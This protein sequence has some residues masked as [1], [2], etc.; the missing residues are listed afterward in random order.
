MARPQTTWTA[1]ALLARTTDDAGCLVWAGRVHSQSGAPLVDHQGKSRMARR[2]LLALLGRTVRPS[3]FVRCR[4]G[5]PGCIHPDH[6]V[7]LPRATHMREVAASPN[8]NEAVRRA[9]IAATRRARH[10][11][12]TPEQVQEIRASD[13]SGAAIARRL[14]VG[15][16]T[17]N[18]I[19]RG[20]AW[21]DHTSPW[22]G[23]GAR[24]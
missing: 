6:L 14:G 19:R 3:D 7:V 8:R 2:L 11:V 23:M 13:E 5:T 12:L 4:C 21:A 15:K 20:E 24:P 10:A 9:K 1:A 18:S 17:T 16:S 22:A